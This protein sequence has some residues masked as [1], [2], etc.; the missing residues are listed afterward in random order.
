MGAEWKQPFFQ[1]Q[2][3][4]EAAVKGRPNVPVLWVLVGMARLVLPEARHMP[5]AAKP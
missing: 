4:F 1:G 5:G 3:P 2:V